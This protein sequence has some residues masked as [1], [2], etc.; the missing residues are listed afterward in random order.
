MKKSNIMLALAA[1]LA[2]LGSNVALAEPAAFK[3]ADANG[4]GAISKEE[5]LKLRQQPQARTRQRDAN[6]RPEGQRERGEQP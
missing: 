4:D 1:A 5:F 6:N 2:L 3:K